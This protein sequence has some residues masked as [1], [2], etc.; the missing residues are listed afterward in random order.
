MSKERLVAEISNFKRL[1]RTRKELVSLVDEIYNESYKCKDCNNQNIIPLYL[2]RKDY[3]ES[4]G[5]LYVEIFC[6]DCFKVTDRDIFS[7]EI[8]SGIVD[9]DKLEI[10]IEKRFDK[11]IANKTYKVL[12]HKKMI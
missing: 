1:G 8:I 11:D 3:N 10:L 4:K 2:K 5:A 12:K 6:K 7:I 9:S